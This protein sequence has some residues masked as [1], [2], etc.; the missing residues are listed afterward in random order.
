MWTLDAA[1]GTALIDEILVSTDCEDIAEVCNANGFSVPELRPAHLATDTT[2]SIDV[3]RYHLTTRPDVEWVV[4]LQPTSP[5]RTSL[6]IEEAFAT[7]DSA[8]AHKLVSV[9][10]IECPA[11]W[12]H[13]VADGNRLAALD[14]LPKK[15]FRP[16]GAI[17][18]ARREAI[19]AGADFSS[20]GSV[21]FEMPAALS[22]D[23]DDVFDMR[24]ACFFLESA[25]HVSA[26]YGRPD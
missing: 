3:I 5:L 14:P 17:Y 18:I 16:N 10:E 7:L 20:G 8:A 25:R 21:P 4:L 23:V 11:S 1:R 19:L 2:P 24:D 13:F 26:L 6:H 12:V 22:I 9:V 15:L